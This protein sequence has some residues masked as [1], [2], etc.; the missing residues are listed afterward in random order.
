LQAIVIHW[1]AV[2]AGFGVGL[3]PTV[4]HDVRQRQLGAVLGLG[5]KRTL[6]VVQAG[7]QRGV[8][9]LS[10]TQRIILERGL[11]ASPLLRFLFAMREELVALWARSNAS[12]EQLV[13]QLESRLQQ[14]DTS[15][16]I[17]LQ[18]FSKR[19]CGYG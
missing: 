13:E 15:R 8:E 18:Q 1:Y 12:C 17:A 6:Q 11:A 10:A 9:N 14:A 5:E 7:L 19:L 16:V 4:K 3:K 2:L